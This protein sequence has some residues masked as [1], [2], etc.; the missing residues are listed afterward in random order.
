MGSSSLPLL[1][2]LQRSLPVADV[3][4]PNR[5]GRHRQPLAVLVWLRS[6][7]EMG[8]D[9]ASSLQRIGWFLLA[10]LATLT[11]FVVLFGWL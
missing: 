11:I 4:A 9:L 7:G 10:L 1:P 3:K 8:A 5:D 6:G 2:W